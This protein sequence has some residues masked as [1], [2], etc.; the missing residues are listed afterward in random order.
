MLEMLCCMLMQRTEGQSPWM[1]VK[2]IPWRDSWLT[3]S[4]DDTI[5][6][7]DV[8]GCSTMSIPYKGDLL[9]WPACGCRSCA[10]CSLHQ[11]LCLKLLVSTFMGFEAQLSTSTLCLVRAALCLDDALHAAGGA[12][13]TGQPLL[14][15][16]C[17]GTLS[18]HIFN[19]GSAV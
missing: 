1:Q 6:L 19:A 8:E 11:V 17:C 10:S 14:C 18:F 15:M 7:W 13:V 2:W 9:P 3:C 16:V 12:L 5:R 4:D